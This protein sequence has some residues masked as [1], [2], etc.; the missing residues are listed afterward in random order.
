[1][2]R[3]EGPI[4]GRDHVVAVV[5]MVA[6]SLWG[7]VLGAPGLGALTV[8]FPIGMAFGDL[9]GLFGVPIPGVEFGSAVSG[10]VM[11]LMVLF[12]LRPPLWLAALI[13][14]AFAVFHGHP[15][16]CPRGLPAPQWRPRFQRVTP[17]RQRGKSGGEQVRPAPSPALSRSCDGDSVRFP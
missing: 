9:L 1:M 17:W 8:A 12:E 7:A 2:D 14:S 13:V 15:Q 4:S 6:V 11:G 3:A 16:S 5:V 10:L